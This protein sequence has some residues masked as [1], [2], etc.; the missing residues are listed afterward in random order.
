MI[1]N[2]PLYVVIVFIF[3]TLLTVWIFQ[4]T[5]RR[6]SFTSKTTTFLSVTIAFWLIFQGT[7]S[8]L[9]FYQKTDAIP[10]RLFVFAILPALLLIIGLFIFSRDWIEKLPLKGLILLSIIRVPV[11]ICLFWLF[12][13]GQ[14]PQLMTFEGRNFDILSGITAPIIVWIAFRN[15]QV[16]RSLLIIWNI[17]C[18]GLLIN[19]VGHAALSIPSPIQQLAF[20]Q[21][22]QAVLFFPFVW[23]PSTIVPIVLFTHLASFWQIFSNKIRV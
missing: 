13:N 10:P 20:D 1:E 3:T 22:N 7:I 12:Q 11:E 23:L 17:V 19:I 5:A 14:V 2:L 15:G 9:G 21:P 18:L 8:F 4:N 16:N 6:G